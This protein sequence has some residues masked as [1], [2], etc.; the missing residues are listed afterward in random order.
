[1]FFYPF[2]SSFSSCIFGQEVYVDNILL[3]SILIFSFF[4]GMIIFFLPNMKYFCMYR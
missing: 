1:M 4:L 3:T 2:V